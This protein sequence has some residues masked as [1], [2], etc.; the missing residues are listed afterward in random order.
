M[1]LSR[2]FALSFAILAVVAGSPAGGQEDEVARHYQAALAAEGKRDFK[3]A[4]SE[5]EKVLDLDSEHADALGRWEACEKL[6][7]WQEALGGKAP[8]AADLVRLGEVYCAV[9]RF[10][11][12]RKAYEDAIVLDPTCHDAHGHL[13]MS[14]YTAGGGSIVTVIRETRRFLETSPRRKNLARAIADWEIF[15]ELRIFT[16]VLHK[17]LKAA[18]E[19][20]EAG[21]ALEAAGIL[22]AAVRNATPDVYRTVLCVRAG[23][24]RL[25]AGDKEGARKCFT[26]ALEHAKCHATI[27]ARLA[28]AELDVEKDDLES[29]LVHLRAAVAE[30][31]HACRLIDADAGHAFRPLFISE[32]LEVRAEV[33]KLADPE[34]GDRPIREKIRRAVERAGKEGKKVL[35]EWYGPYCPYVMALE[36]RLQD[37]RIRKILAEHFVFIRMNQGS[38][39]RGITLD[40]EYGNVMRKYGVPCFFVLDAEGHVDTIQ[41]DAELMSVP[42]RA[43]S[44]DKI[45]AWLEKTAR[46]DA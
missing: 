5:Y 6:A 35:L 20:T 46:T 2:F 19:A 37:P 32:N 1:R 22:E 10:K 7:A 24:L 45:A 30:G 8:T 26:R 12:E 36:D 4:L 31:S 3:T 41:R 28:L 15:G 18:K 27:G 14:H 16:Q 44:V 42:N 33:K 43:F 38:M 13:A 11:E 39:H 23:K 21:K 29:A 9:S 25:E 34:Y 17:E 40:K